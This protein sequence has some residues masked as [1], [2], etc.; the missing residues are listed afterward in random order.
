MENSVKNKLWITLM[1]SSVLILGG[2]KLAPVHN[3]ENAAI[4]ATMK[5]LSADQISEAIV[6]AG[7]GLGWKMHPD[8][9]AK[10]VIGVLT[11]RKHM[12]KVRVNYTDEFYSIKYVDSQNLKYDGENIHNNYNGWIQNLDRAIQ[13]QLNLL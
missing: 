11:L 4:S 5:T 9:D 2:C 8:V 12:A 6:R 3:V 10:E 1:I 13:T 7:S